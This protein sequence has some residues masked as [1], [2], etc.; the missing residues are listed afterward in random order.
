[1]LSKNK[2]EETIYCTPKL[3][4]NSGDF[5]LDFCKQDQGIIFLPDF[6]AKKDQDAGKIMRC[7]EDYHS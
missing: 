5:L 4:C 7:L 2:K 6:L 3:T 1:M